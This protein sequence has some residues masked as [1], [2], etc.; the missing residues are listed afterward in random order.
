MFKLH[1]NRCTECQICQQI[2]SWEHYGHH[3]PKRARIRINADWPK[4]PDIHV[5]LACPER[6]CIEACPNQALSW[7]GWVHVDKELCDSCG[8]CIEVCPAGGIHLDPKTMIPLVCDTCGGQ[9]LCVKWCPTHAIELKGV[10]D[11]E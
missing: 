6:E 4:S 9:Y 7:E 8:V 10:P 5:C 1:S 3:A 11:H 2:C